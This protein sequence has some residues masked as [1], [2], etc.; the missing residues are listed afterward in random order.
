MQRLLTYTTQNI[1]AGDSFSCTLGSDSSVKVT[2]IQSSRTENTAGSAF[3]EAL[4]TTTH[5]SRIT[6]FNTHPFP[7]ASLVVRDVIPTS[8]DKNIKVILRNPRQ[9]ATAKDGESVDLGESDEAKRDLFVGWVK[10][11]GGKGGEKEGRFEW[12]WKVGNGEKVVLEAEWDI[13][14]LADIVFGEVST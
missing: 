6:V 12:K 5:T 8:E 4:T 9:L 3:V 2:Y 1:N 13:Q 14:T 11:V 10:A 7:L